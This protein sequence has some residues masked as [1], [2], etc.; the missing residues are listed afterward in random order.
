V[1]HVPHRTTGSSS[2]SDIVTTAVPNGDSYK[3]TG[4]NIHLEGIN[5]GAETIV[6]L[7]WLVLKGAPAEQRKYHF[8]LC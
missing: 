7:F 5:K 2:L 8:L 3:D 1:V 6:H 4:Q